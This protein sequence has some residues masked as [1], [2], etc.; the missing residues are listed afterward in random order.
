I[1]RQRPAGDWGGFYR[2]TDPH[3]FPS[4]HAA[5]A[6]LLLGLALWLG[7]DWFRLAM[8]IYSPLMALA[9]ISMGVHYLSD[10][11]AGYALG[12]LLAASS[13][14]WLSRIGWLHALIAG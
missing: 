7:P 12:L 1:R 9:R 14:W 4:G 11:V 8:L 6:A 13:G 3:S 2:R 10:V 5:R